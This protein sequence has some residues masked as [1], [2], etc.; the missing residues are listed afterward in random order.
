MMI[1]HSTKCF[2]G[3]QPDFHHLIVF[4][5]LCISKIETHQRKLLL[6]GKKAVFTGYGG[7]T[8]A[9]IFLIL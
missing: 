2:F 9:Y 8:P 1:K 4:G 6:K 3:K 7:S 5:C